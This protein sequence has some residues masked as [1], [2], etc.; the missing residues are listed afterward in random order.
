MI[1]KL[2]DHVLIWTVEASLSSLHKKNTDE[3]STDEKST[4][5]ECPNKKTPKN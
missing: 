3:N 2:A 1:S 5:E 4:N